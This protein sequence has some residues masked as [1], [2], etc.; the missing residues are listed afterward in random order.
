MPLQS[1]RGSVAIANE[2]I[3]RWKVLIVEDDPELWP[4]L[5][6]FSEAADPGVEIE[7]AGNA[8]EAEERLTSGTRY[9]A[10]VTDYCLP[11]PGA[12]KAILDRATSLQPWA[13]VGMVS[14]LMGFEPEKGTPFL[15]KPFTRQTYL[16]FLR[17]LL[18]WPRSAQT[19]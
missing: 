13:R 19:R 10:I 18:L 6:R 8:S 16:R 3:G 11:R 7:F 5:E 14:A 4:I 9:N 17:N 15:A 12:G 2:E 1:T